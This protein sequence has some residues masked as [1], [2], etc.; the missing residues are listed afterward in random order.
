MTHVFYLVRRLFN[1]R[2]ITGKYIVSPK[3]SLDQEPI[4]MTCIVF[5]TEL[6]RIG[7]SRYYSLPS[8]HQSYLDTINFLFEEISEV[9]YQTYCQ[10]DLFPAKDSDLFTIKDNASF[11]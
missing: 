2:D 9:Q 7:I 5:D 4:A 8:G 11:C 10:F 6:S 1:D 3:Y